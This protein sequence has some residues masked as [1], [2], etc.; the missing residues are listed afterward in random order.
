MLAAR[1]RTLRCAVVAREY[2]RGSVPR[3]TSLNWTMPEFVNISVGSLP[4]TRLDERTIVWPFDSKNLRNFSR[5]SAAFMACGDSL[6]KT[7]SNAGALVGARGG[8]DSE[9]IDYTGSGPAS[10]QSGG[11]RLGPPAG[12]GGPLAQPI[13]L[14]MLGMPTGP[15]RQGEP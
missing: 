15:A 3:N 14:K 11:K 6:A 2:G 5:I 12:P 13:R 7:A 10:G 4:G 9:T 1:A 8:M